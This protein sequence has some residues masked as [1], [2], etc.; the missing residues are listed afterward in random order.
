LCAAAGAP[1]SKIDATM[2]C[3]MTAVRRMAAGQE[4]PRADA[5]KRH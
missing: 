5:V 2:T 3:R 4:N 1:P